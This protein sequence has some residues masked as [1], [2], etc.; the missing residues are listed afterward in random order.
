MDN[1]PN[2]DPFR[3]ALSID[4]LRRADRFLFEQHRRRFIV[5]RAGLRQVLG[6]Y[7]GIAAESV[8]FDYTGLGKP[9]LRGHHVGR[10]LC[11]NFS[12][13]HERALLAVTLDLEIGVDIERLRRMDS[14][15]GL[16]NRFF[17]ESEKRQILSMAEPERTEAFFCCWTRKEAFLK[18]I[19]K[20][21]TFPLCNVAVDVRRRTAAKIISIHGD[22]ETEESESMNAIKWSLS[23]IDAESDYVAALACCRLTNHVSNYRWIGTS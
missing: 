5:G 4:E 16:A 18:A 21:L 19:G 22:A 3:R 15:E 23:H 6:S 13:S 1:A 11:F 8:A 20:G 9:R 7:L 17:A 10:G 12:N 2:L 14:L